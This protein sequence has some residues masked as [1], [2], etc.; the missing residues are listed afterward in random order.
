MVHSPTHWE[1]L[2][3]GFGLVEGPTVEPGG[4]LVFSDVLGGGVHRLTA[5]GV[6]TTII[7]KRRG[8]GGIALHR[9][10]GLV[11]SGRDVQYVHDGTVETLL[12]IDG[13]PGFNDLCTDALGRVY[14]GA[15]RFMVFDPTA[16]HEPGELWR[17]DID[18]T[19]KV[20]YDEVQHC[21]GVALSSDGA[22]IYHSD[23]RDACVVVHDLNDDG[24]VATNRRHW[25]MGPKSHPDGLAV[26]ETGAVWVAD[27]G[28]GRVVRFRPN[29][30]I[31]GSIDV[32]ATMVTSLCFRGSDLVVVTADNSADPDARGS[33]FS[34]N[35][36]VA[37]APV[38]AAAVTRSR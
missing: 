4:N 18:G 11:V 1:L 32:P 25:P 10:G 33:I 37:G 38:H 5:A 6:V 26:D 9:D 30:I 14:A 29:G 16:T 22:T 8:V 36:G 13:L 2:A 21:N 3:S 7:P 19:A 17:I 20:L 23:T 15:V 35:L 27:A 34:A 31:D 28:A 24:S 12:A